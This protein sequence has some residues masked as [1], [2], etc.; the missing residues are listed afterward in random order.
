MSVDERVLGVI[1]SI[2]DAALDESRWPETLSHL[3]DITGSQAATFWVLDG[4]E[5]PRLPLF[6]Y[7][8]LDRAFIQEYGR[9]SFCRLRRLDGR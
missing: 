9:I 2:Y 6:N 5:G 3:S 4:S 7:I 8:N 1:Q